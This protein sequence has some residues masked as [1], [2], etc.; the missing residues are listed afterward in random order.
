[1]HWVFTNKTLRKNIMIR[2]NM[3]K[4]RLMMIL[5]ICV[6]SLWGCLE[7]GV[8][9]IVKNNSGNIIKN[10]KLSYVGG[11]IEAKAINDKQNFSTY[12]NPIS[13]SGLQVQFL[14]K[15]GKLR[16]KTIDVY[17]EKNYTGEIKITITPDY[18]LIVSDDVHI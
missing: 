14:D 13:E 11:D 8:L 1:M 7:K 18:S 12:V 17:M 3:D 10:L 2:N 6:A 16:K 9:V 15:N 4:Y 5:L